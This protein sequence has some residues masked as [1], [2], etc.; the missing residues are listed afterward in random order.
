MARSEERNITISNNS[1]SSSSSKAS[2]WGYRGVRMRH[3]ENGSPKSWEPRK[4]SR[5]W[6]GNLR[7]P[8]KMAARAH[9]VAALAIQGQLCYS[10]TSRRD[11]P[12]LA[13]PASRASPRDVQAARHQGRLMDDVLDHRR[14]SP[15]LT[16]SSSS[17]SSSLVSSIASPEPAEE[18]GEIVELPSLDTS[19]GTLEGSRDGD[20][21]F[22]AGLLVGRLLQSA[23]VIQFR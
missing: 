2:I 4:K 13:P 17:S 12:P 16:S 14:D 7:D 8:G 11:I 9:D 1:S 5:I 22:G 18:L 19:Y 15:S 21:A 6:L 23:G 3:G 20:F 10:Q